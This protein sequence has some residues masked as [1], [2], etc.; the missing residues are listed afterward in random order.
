MVL[1][2]TVVEVGLICEGL[3]VVRRDYAELAGE[4][5][6]PVIKSGLFTA[7]NSFTQQIFSDE[8]EELK[9]KRFTI[10]IKILEVPD[11]S[12]T[13]LYAVVDTEKSK[14]RIKAVKEALNR[15]TLS[16]IELL[17]KQESFLDV[18]RNHLLLEE[19]DREMKNYRPVE[20]KIPFAINFKTKIPKSDYF[21]LIYIYRE[22]M[23]NFLEVIRKFEKNFFIK[24]YISE[25]LEKHFKITELKGVKI[26]SHVIDRIIEELKLFD[27]EESAEIETI[28]DSD[29]KSL[30]ETEKSSLV[31]MLVSIPELA[32]KAQTEEEEENKEPSTSI[33]EL[34]KSLTSKL[35]KINFEVD[36]DDF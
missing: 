11:K 4:E 14:I 36:D 8:A 35:K 6:D 1:K 26:P 30:I 33:A 21:K 20:E 28:S 2:T 27:V 23:N 13:F 25:G 19:I 3:P 12:Y 22:T 17:M 9:L 16:S 18:S 15:L 31:D 7:L 24:S 5:V 10:C 32:E 34:R 29:E